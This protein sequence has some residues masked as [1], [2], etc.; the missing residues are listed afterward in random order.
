MDFL[1]NMHVDKLVANFIANPE[2]L[3]MGSSLLLLLFIIAMAYMVRLDIDPFVFGRHFSFNSLLE[4]IVFWPAVASV[5]LWTYYFPWTWP[6]ETQQGF[7]LNKFTIGCGLLLLLIIGRAVTH[8]LLREKDHREFF[9]QFPYYLMVLFVLFVPT[10]YYFQLER[11]GLMPKEQLGFALAV[12]YIGYFLVRLF[13]GRSVMIPRIGVAQWLLYFIIYMLLTVVIMPYRLAAIKNVIQWIAFAVCF[14]AAYA[15]I[16]DRRRRDSIILMVIITA[17]I[18]TLWGLWKYFD[19][20]YHLVGMTATGAQDYL[21]KTPSA[22]RYFLLAGLFANPNYY[23]E[24]LAMTIFLAFGLFFSTNSKNVRIFLGSVLA[25]NCFEMVALYN[26]AGWFGMFVAAGFVATGLLIAR[27]PVFKR[28]SKATVIS[29]L[30]GLILILTITSVVFNQRDAGG[31][32][33]LAGTPF[34]R[35]KSMTD[36]QDDETFRNRLTMWRA[37]RFMVTDPD[38]FPQ[39]LIFG[40][41]FGFFEVEYLPYQTEVL[42]T[43]DFKEWFHNVIPTFRAH[44]DHI[45]MLVEAG[46]I[47]TFLYAMIFISFFAYGFK[48]VREEEDAARRFLAL[49]IMAAVASCLASAMFSFPLHKIQQGSLAFTMMGFLCVEIFQRNRLRKY[50]EDDEAENTTISINVPDLECESDFNPEA[51]AAKST[52]K[53]KKSKKGGSNHIDVSPELYYTP[54]NF[55][56]IERRFP[57]WLSIPL[58]LIVS[59]LT[60]WGVYTQVINFKAHYLV[61]KGIQ[62]IRSIP[63]DPNDPRKSRYAQTA[64]N[65]FW[66]AYQLD[67]TNGR[68]EFFHGFALTKVGEYEKTVAGTQHLEKGQELYPQSDTFYALAMG[69]ELRRN[70]ARDRAQLIQQEL[71]AQNQKLSITEDDTERAEIESRMQELIGAQ[72]TYQEDVDYSQE[73]AIESY[74]TAA[75]Y[76]PVKIEYYKEL[77]R[78]LKEEARWQDVI[79]WADAA[80]IVDD[81]LLEKPPIRWELYLSLGQAHR[82]LGN[83]AISEAQALQEQGDIEGSAAKEQE[84][85]EHYDAAFEALASSINIASRTYYPYFEVGQLHEQ[86]GNKALAE[87]HMDEAAQHYELAKNA[88]IDCFT[89]KANV[90]KGEAP[91]DYAYFLLGRIYEKLGGDENTARAT[92]YYRQL[93]EVSNYT[94]DQ[95]PYR[96]A[97]IRYHELTGEWIGLEPS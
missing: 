89:Y 46:I 18:S 54:E 69:Y 73:R 56:R 37:A 23:G 64:A 5:L 35:L 53:K 65:Y 61:V 79:D 26:R 19:I 45:Q 88:Y 63:D 84:F 90:R 50:I 31:D 30:I 44:N 77:I 6:A 80:L 72:Q 1:V 27:V 29:G 57:V 39:R 60:L 55:I 13:I 14:L 93:I 25:I 48:Y 91:F 92:G 87:D 9:D 24:W 47:G 10:V 85:N 40:G 28:V 21:Y 74:A 32:T 86:L 43:Y 17:L 67:P 52:R 82:Y 42:R 75:T 33:P 62:I 51:V 59:F 95:D 81:W 15:Y 49:G 83:T 3:H 36:F 12:V 20:P 58:I 97:R 76:Y 68:A 22:G 66:T 11:N 38:H 4:K 96:Q 2:W 78:L 41:G 34:E 71:D 94:P 70:Q 16:P 8:L 7:Y